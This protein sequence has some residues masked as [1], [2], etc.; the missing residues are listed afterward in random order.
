MA[1]NQLVTRNQ[2]FVDNARPTQ[3]VPKVP[4]HNSA[5]SASMR[6]TNSLLANLRVGPKDLSHLFSH[7]IVEVG[8]TELTID[9]E[10]WAFHA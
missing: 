5:A 6:R 1:S 2:Y 7:E 8:K 4:K 3:S 9:C 10:D